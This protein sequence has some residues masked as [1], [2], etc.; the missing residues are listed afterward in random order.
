MMMMMMMM[1]SSVVVDFCGFAL[2]F[3]FYAARGKEV[4]VRCAQ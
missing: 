3:S 4:L 1:M 2:L